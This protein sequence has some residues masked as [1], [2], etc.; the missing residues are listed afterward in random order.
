LRL[1]DQIDFG[2]SGEN[3]GFAVAQASPGYLN[4][5]VA[6]FYSL[7]GRKIFVF[8]GHGGSPLMSCSVLNDVKPLQITTRLNAHFGQDFGWLVTVLSAAPSAT[9]TRS[10]EARIADG[11]NG[12]GFQ[13]LCHVNT[14]PRTVSAER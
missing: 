10:R 12:V 14:F 7:S 1:I 6:V 8:S 9:V 4:L 5:N 11:A 2:A 13:V 3:R